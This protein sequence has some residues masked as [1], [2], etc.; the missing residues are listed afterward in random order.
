M[1]FPPFR[2]RAVVGQALRIRGIGLLAEPRYQALWLP[3]AVSA[4]LGGGRMRPKEVK[5]GLK[6]LYRHRT[7]IALPAGRPTFYGCEKN[8][9]NT[10]R[11]KR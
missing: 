3:R 5:S 9:N 10:S 8:T 11:Q 2:Q 4:G 1:G 7:E 6:A